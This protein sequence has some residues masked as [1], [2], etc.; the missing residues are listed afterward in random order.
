MIDLHECH[1]VNG[2]EWTQ[3]AK[4]LTAQKLA[5]VP[6]INRWKGRLFAATKRLAYGVIHQRF[7]R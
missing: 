4:E 2:L 7:I 5:T 1:R 3:P 6:S